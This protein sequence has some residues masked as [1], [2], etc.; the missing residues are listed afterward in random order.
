MPESRSTDLAE[1]VAQLEDERAI[2]ATLYAYGAAL[3]YGDKE[4][5]LGCFTPDADYLVEMRMQPDNGFRHRGHGELGAY[6][7]GHTHAPSAYHKHIT[8]NPHVTCDGD[9]ARASSY[10]VRVDASDT[11][12]PAVVLASGRYVDELARDAAGRWRIKSRRCEVEN[13]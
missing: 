11:S 12:G 9:T 5:F 1:R 6:F 2:V 3:D 7:D 4:L 8:T 13:M 10:F